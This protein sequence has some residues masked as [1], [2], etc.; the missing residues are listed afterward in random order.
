MKRQDFW[1]SMESPTLE[2]HFEPPLNKWISIIREYSVGSE[3]HLYWYNKTATLSTF[4]GAIWKSNGDLLQDYKETD[5]ERK[6]NWRGNIDLWFKVKHAH[7]LAE[8]T[9]RWVSFEDVANE[10]IVKKRVACTNQE[11]IDSWKGNRDVTPITITFIVPFMD[12]EKSLDTVHLNGKINELIQKIED[13]K[14]RLE[15]FAYVFPECQFD[16]ADENKNIYPGV[17]ILIQKCIQ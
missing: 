7:Y 4:A 15:A 8:V 10:K 5:G 16:I 2:T 14:N 1:I 17:A 6:G 9:Q 12:K 11:A 3:D 13:K